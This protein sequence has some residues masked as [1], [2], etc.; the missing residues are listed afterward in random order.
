[1]LIPHGKTAG[2]SQFMDEPPVKLT[3]VT[4]VDFDMPIWSMMSF[5]IKLAIA[6][7]PAAFIIAAGY[8][9]VVYLFVVL[10]RHG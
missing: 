5:M 8:A 7:I 10:G 1:M 3:P 9:G 2:S 6:A 4:I